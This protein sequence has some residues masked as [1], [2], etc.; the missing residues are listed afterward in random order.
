MIGPQFLRCSE[1]TSINYQGA[2]SRLCPPQNFSSVFDGHQSH[3]S[4]RLIVL[5][6]YLEA[7]RPQRNKNNE[8]QQFIGANK[9]H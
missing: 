8:F 4:A 7:T 6:Q 9:P 2:K 3:L 1:L 5:E